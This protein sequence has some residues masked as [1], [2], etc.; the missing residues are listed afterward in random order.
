MATFDLPEDPITPFDDE[1]AVELPVHD[2]VL[3]EAAPRGDS[4]AV[5]DGT[6]GRAVGYRELA[7]TTRRLAA[8][9]A[10]A[11]VEQGDV[12]AL[13]GTNLTVYPLVLHACSRAG[14]VVYVMD[15]RTTE[16][17]LRAQLAESGA[18]WL[19]ASRALL[20]AALRVCRGLAPGIRPVEGVF[21][22][23]PADGRRCVLDLAATAAPEPAVDIDPAGDIAVVHPSAGSRRC[24]RLTHSDLAA[25]LALLASD[26]PLDAGERVL[27]GVPFA[28]REGLSFLALH[29]LRSGAAVVVMPELMNIPDLLDAVR[30]H[31]VETVFVTQTVLYG[32]VAAA[33][34]DP[35]ELGVL[36]RVVVTGPELGAATEETCAALLGVRRIEYLGRREYAAAL[37]GPPLL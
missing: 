28:D 19:I 35:S 10:G 21:T 1:F 36:R 24:V 8:G 34:D 18:R 2:T 11:G 3:G 20:P 32:L 16:T 17:A 15:G 30:V 27:A 5:V 4:P 23:E 6:T 22:L 12:V 29:A 7:G 37:P 33:P 31:R 9:L 26:N 13:L 25:D 14:A